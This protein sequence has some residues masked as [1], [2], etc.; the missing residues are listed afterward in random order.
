MAVGSNVFDYKTGVNV[1][2]TIESSEGSGK[3]FSS[4]SLTIPFSSSPVF[5]GQGAPGQGQ[6]ETAGVPAGAHRRPSETRHGR[7]GVWC[8]ATGAS[9]FRSSQVCLRACL[10]YACLLV[11]AVD[12]CGCCR[13]SFVAAVVVVVVAV[14][15]CGNSVFGCGNSV[16][17]SR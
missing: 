3:S 13:S 12:C 7:R 11:A 1:I 14:F 5:Q 6:A 17:A 2:L 16:P 10:L 4:K 8:S 9:V 15:G